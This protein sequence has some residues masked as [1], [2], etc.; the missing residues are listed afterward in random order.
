MKKSGWYKINY[1]S[2]YVEDGKVIRAIM[3]GWEVNAT[4]Y[5]YRYN[6]RAGCWINASGELSPGALRAGLRRGTIQLM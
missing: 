3:D 6:K 5:P 4:R 1:Y 2:V